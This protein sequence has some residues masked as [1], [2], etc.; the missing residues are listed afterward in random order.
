M[1]ADWIAHRFAAIARTLEGEGFE[2][3]DVD[4]ALV[5]HRRKFQLSRFGVVDT[6]VSLLAVDGEASADDLRGHL[7]RSI[8]V[9]LTS[10]S[11]IPRGLGSAVELHPVTLA[12]GADPSA[13]DEATATTPNRWS[14][15]IIPALIPGAD[16]SVVTYEGRK[17]WGGAYHAALLRRL[18]TW[19]DA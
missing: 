16:A 9:A 8:E 7:D 17:V 15:M 13:L 10:K 14:M 12:S 4:G 3:R 2:R 1:S 6:F 5:L 18:R 11:G 19:L